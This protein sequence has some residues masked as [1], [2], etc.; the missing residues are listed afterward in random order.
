VI[1][2]TTSN[3]LW[4]GEDDPTIGSALEKLGA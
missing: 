1:A 4:G 2:L 3:Q